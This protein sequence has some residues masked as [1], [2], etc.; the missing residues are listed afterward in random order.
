[1]AMNDDQFKQSM[2]RIDS[3]SANLEAKFPGQLPTGIKGSR[4]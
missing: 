1:M 3:S 2:D 4:R